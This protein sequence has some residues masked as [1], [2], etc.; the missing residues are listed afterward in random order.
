MEAARAV[1]E[2]LLVR[3]GPDQAGGW[4]ALCT[5][6]RDTALGRSQLQCVTSV[7]AQGPFGARSLGEQVWRDAGGRLA[8]LP[9]QW[10][11]PRDARACCHEL[12]A[13][14]ALRLAFQVEEEPGELRAACQALQSFIHRVSLLRPK[15]RFHYCVNVQGAISAQTYCEPSQAGVCVL[16]G[17]E[18]VADWRHYIQPGPPGTPVPCRKLHPVLGRATRLLLPAAVAEA[19]ISGELSLVPAAAL[20]PCLRPLPNQPAQLNTVSVFC[21]DPAGLPLP[22]TFL[23]DPAHLADW[24]RHGYVATPDPGPDPKEGLA[25]PDAGYLLHRGGGDAA[26]P[27]AQPQTLLLFLL[28]RYADPFQDPPVCDARTQQV[29]VSHV[30]QILGCSAGAVR[31]AVQGVVDAALEEDAHRQRSQRRLCQALPVVLE[32]VSSV[33]SS[34]TSA[35]FRRACLQSWQVSDTPELVVAL[36]GALTGVTRRRRLP[37]SSCTDPGPPWAGSPPGQ[38]PLPEEASR[39]IG[40]PRSEPAGEAAGA[41]P[42]PKQSRRASGTPEQGQSRDGAGSSQDLSQADELW[43]Q[44]TRSLSE[45]AS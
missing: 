19:G 9:V 38:P 29:L 45:W 3:L 28:L 22:A 2:Q 40:T 10:I 33:V 7:A 12:L 30:E 13:P 42:E 18:L 11:S 24:E 35:R 20:C 43:L 41:G 37:R 44:E 8:E 1:V 5:E 39:D 17:T 23:R 27:G 21:Y 15:M 34:S 31:E 4:L 25:R 14:D 26:E 16:N 6:A 32:A 36:S